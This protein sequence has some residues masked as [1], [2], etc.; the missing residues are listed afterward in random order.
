MFV[1][2]HNISECLKIKKIDKGC[3]IQKMNKGCN[4]SL[5]NSNQWSIIIF[6]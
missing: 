6:K 4:T 1:K 2:I 3:L 5:K